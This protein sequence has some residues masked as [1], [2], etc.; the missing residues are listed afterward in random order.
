[1]SAE[2]GRVGRGDDQRRLRERHQPVPRIGAGSSR[3]A[4]RST[5]PAYFRPADGVKPPL[6][7]RSVRR[8]A[9]RADREEQGVLLRRLR[10]VQA[11]ARRDGD[12]DHR[13]RGAA[14]GILAV[15]VRDPLTGELVPGGHA[16]SD[17]DVRAQGAERAAG[18][19]QLGDASNNYQ[20]LQ[21]FDEHDAQGRRQGRRAD[22]PD[23]VGLRPLRLARLRHLRRTRRSR[24]RRAA[25]A[26]RIIYARN[27]QLAFGT[28][29]TPTATSLLEVRF[30][31]ST[32]ARP[33]RTL[34]RSAQPSALDA[35]GITGL[36]TDPRVVG[37]L[38]TQLIT[39]YSDLGPTGD[40][41][42]VAVP[43]G[44]QPEES[45][46]PG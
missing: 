43:D 2:Y 29:Y 3:A 15:D 14:Q 16:D 31:W 21:N 13:H 42:A 18:A 37:G 17:D 11:D 8:R 44:L 36:P 46:T 9:R 22:Q 41:S 4:P 26:T 10:G 20:L 28:T 6:R 19:D 1:M 25:P 40:Q 5:R 30:G 34:R 35:Y 33:A 23:A 38:P 45:T 24:C 27:K 12:H 39:G 7:A 32:H